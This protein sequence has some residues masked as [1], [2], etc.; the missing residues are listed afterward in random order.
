MRPQ[1]GGEFYSAGLCER[2]SSSAERLKRDRPQPDRAGLDQRVVDGGAAGPCLIE[3]ID[4]Q[5]GVLGDQ[6]HQHDEA[7]HAEDV[8][9]RAGDQQPEEDADQRHRQRHRRFEPEIGR[10]IAAQANRKQGLGGLE[11]AVEVDEARDLQ[12]AAHDVL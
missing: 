1:W 12:G 4:Q 3:E 10:C 8:E 11:V 9:R 2:A 5:D 6:A 7:D